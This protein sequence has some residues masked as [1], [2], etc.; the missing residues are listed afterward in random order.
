MSRTEPSEKYRKQKPYSKTTALP[1]NG[2]NDKTLFFKCLKNPEFYELIQKSFCIQHGPSTSLSFVPR[3]VQIA[4][5]CLQK[6]SVPSFEYNKK[7]EI[8][9]CFRLYFKKCITVRKIYF[10][11]L[12]YVDHY[13]RFPPNITEA[14]INCSITYLW[15]NGS[16]V[17]R[18]DK[19]K[20]QSSLQIIIQWRIKKISNLGPCTT[21]CSSD[22]GN[23]RIIMSSLD[24]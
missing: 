10:S 14:E 11:S 9:M 18:N 15:F 7:C 21:F 24:A 6:P 19:W 17:L 12:K 3:G 4:Y 16:N 20:K 23:F 5:M 13:R 2:H 1:P 22:V 8:C